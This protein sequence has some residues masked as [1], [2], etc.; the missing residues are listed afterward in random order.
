LDH[1]IN[2]P[3]YD[4]LFKLLLAGTAKTGKTS[5]LYQYADNTFPN[6]D[7]YKA[8][9][10]IDFKVRTVPI[11]GKI[12]KLQIWDSAGEE[13]FKS[14]ARAYYRGA[15]TCIFNFDL[16]SVESFQGVKELME[17]TVREHCS[18]NVYIVLAGNKSDL[19]HA[20]N[21]TDIVRFRQEWNDKN[22]DFRIQRYFETSAKNNH[23]V[24]EL[25]ETTAAELLANLYKDSSLDK[26]EPR[27]KQEPS[28]QYLKTQFVQAFKEQ[29]SEDRAKFCGLFR[30]FAKSLMEPRLDNISLNN[31][32]FHAQTANN[33][34]REVCVKLGWLTPNGRIADNAPAAI[35]RLNEISTVGEN[36]VRT[37]FT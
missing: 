24:S 10:G 18:S 13:R 16:N 29:I 8:T 26:Q 23:N 14:I 11:N 25:F 7:V 34:S 2:V 21:P 9:I 17:Q 35:R 22:P 28:A 31:I 15:M 3:R 5:L 30:F 37:S 19:P 4:Y 6:P 12:L 20:V 33:R 36:T 27:D 1:S 32:I